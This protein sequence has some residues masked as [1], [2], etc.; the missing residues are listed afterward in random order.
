MSYVVLA[1]VAVV[2]GYGIYAFNALTRLR[3]LVKEGWSGCR[4]S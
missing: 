3:N 2:A 4:V 1:I